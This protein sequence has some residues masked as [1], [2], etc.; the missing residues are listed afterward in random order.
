[1]YPLQDFKTSDVGNVKYVT[2]PEYRRK[3]YMITIGAKLRRGESLE[4]F[5]TERIKSFYLAKYGKLDDKSKLSPGE[6]AE[7]QLKQEKISKESKPFKPISVPLHGRDKVHSKQ[8]ADVSK[9]WEKKSL[10]WVCVEEEDGP[11]FYSHIGKQGHFHHTSFNAAGA[12]L[13]AGEWIVEKGKLL[14]ISANS[15][16]YQPTVHYLYNCLL[17]LAQACNDD[18]TVFVWSKELKQWVDVPHKFFKEEPESFTSHPRSV[19]TG[20]KVRQPMDSVYNV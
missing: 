7:L 1:M 14:R 15:G 16:H 5:D 20:E 2:K 18:T 13:G 12:L 11:T 10:I 19:V 17:L 3:K 4:E 6:Q 9:E 8:L